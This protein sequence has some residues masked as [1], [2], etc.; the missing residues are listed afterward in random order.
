MSNLQKNSSHEPLVRIEKRKELD[1]KQA[2]LLRIGA[3]LL[4]IIV[5]GLFI[6]AM[7]KNPFQAYALIIKGAFV[8]G[9]RNPFSSIQ[10]TVIKWVPLLITSL[11][12]SFAFKMKFWNIGAEGQIMMGAIFTGYFAIFHSDWPRYIL[13]PVMFVAGI[14]GGGLWALIP[15]IFKV[16]FGT[17]ETLFTL[18]LNYVATYIIVYLESGPWQGTKGYASVSRYAQNALLPKFG[19]IHIGWII[20]AVLTVIV[21]V[22]FSKTK[23]GYEISVVGESPATAKYAGMS[24]TK[25]ILRTMFISGAVCGL[26]GMIQSTGYDNTLTTG[27]TGGVGWTGIIVAWL[28]QLQPIMIAIVSALFAILQKGSTLMQSTL[29]ISSFAADVLQSIILFFVLGSEFFVRY[30][31]AFKKGENK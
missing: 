7:G 1:Q 4:A 25:I 10:A 24:V 20:A 12:L 19:G 27:V 6:A 17:N 13:I 11:G 18:M 30:K 22:Y 14:I 2:V 9:R 16:K 5:G 26:A 3:L 23:Q 8:G 29:G 15:A 21:A 31:F 28:A